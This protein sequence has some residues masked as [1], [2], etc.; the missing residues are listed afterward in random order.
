MYL[1]CGW[2]SDTD[3]LEESYSLYGVKPPVRPPSGPPRSP[4]PPGAPPPLPPGQTYD[5]TR[6]WAAPC[7]STFSHFTVGR[8]R[9]VERRSPVN[10]LAFLIENPLY[11]AELVS[12]LSRDTGSDWLEQNRIAFFL[13]V[14]SLLGFISIESC[15][16]RETKHS[17]PLP[18]YWSA[19]QLTSSTQYFGISEYSIPSMLTHGS[20]ATLYRDTLFLRFMRM[21]LDTLLI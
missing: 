10:D 5:T 1:C 2:C 21:H 15:H 6:Y 7:H 19:G 9:D 20:L 4:F 3:L 16:G 11:C 17:I 12:W 14:Y 18:L 8:D 13:H